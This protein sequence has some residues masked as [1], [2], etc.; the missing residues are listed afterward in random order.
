M[1][2]SELQTI[3]H[4]VLVV[5]AGG[6]R[7]AEHVEGVGVVLAAHAIQPG[8]VLTENRP[9]IGHLAGQRVFGVDQKLRK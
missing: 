1:S 8:K 3:E 7:I 2:V 9:K 6:G 5:G 4:D